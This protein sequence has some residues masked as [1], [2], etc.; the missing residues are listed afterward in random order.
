MAGSKV[1]ESKKKTEGSTNC[2]FLEANHEDCIAKSISSEGETRD[3]SAGL[4]LGVLCIP[5]STSPIFVFQI[6]HCCV[7]PAPPVL[8]ARKLVSELL[9]TSFV[10]SDNF[11]VC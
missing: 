7:E 11:V 3:T 10:K 9:S 5:L 2:M 8:W 4:F 1:Q 6:M